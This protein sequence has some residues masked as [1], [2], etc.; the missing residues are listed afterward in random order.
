MFKEKPLVDII[1]STIAEIELGADNEIYKVTKFENRISLSKKKLVTIDGKRVNVT[2]SYGLEPL[3]Y[4]KYDNHIKYIK[5]F[6]EPIITVQLNH[7]TFGL[8]TGKYY[9]VYFT[10]EGE[11][12]G[13]SGELVLG[14]DKNNYVDQNLD[15]FLELIHKRR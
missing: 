4:L 1:T 3:S 11:L 10:I 5:Y 12:V 2:V 9:R 8:N 14:D 6:S 13:E 15:E 7:N